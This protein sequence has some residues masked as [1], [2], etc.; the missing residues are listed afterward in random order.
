[1]RQ[2]KKSVLISEILNGDAVIKKKGQFL[3]CRITI[4]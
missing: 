4:K 2:K 3:S 1:M